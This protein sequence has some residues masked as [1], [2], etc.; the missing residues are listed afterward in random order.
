MSDS[1]T[2]NSAGSRSPRRTTPGLLPNPSLDALALA[3]ALAEMRAAGAIPRLSALIAAQP[4]ATGALTDA[5][6]AE[7]GERLDAMDTEP[8]D[9]SGDV[10]E[11]R[12]DIED[13]PVQLS[14]GTQQAIAAI[15]SAGDRLTLA[16]DRAAGGRDDAVALVAEAPALYSVSATTSATGGLGL[17]A[18]ADRQGFDAE[19]LAAKMMLS[20]DVLHW[21]DRIALPLE[22]Q[23]DA[24][25]AHL[26]G[27]LGVERDRVSA[28]LTQG[29]AAGGAAAETTDL[30]GML[31]ATESITPVQRSYWSALLSS[32]N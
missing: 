8:G 29:E 2:N 23:P 10:G 7:S 27:A 13:A 1:D 5:T 6:L 18:L 20:A 3:Q 21:L 22:R 15:F 16:G 17:L 24:L 26:V 25:I 31:S 14:L 4:A 28:A 19:T 9:A 32:S 12:E 30:I 11:G